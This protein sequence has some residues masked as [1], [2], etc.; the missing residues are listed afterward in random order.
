MVVAWALPFLHLELECP[1]E[2]IVPVLPVPRQGGRPGPESRMAV[3]Q[4]LLCCVRRV[5]ILT[6]VGT[7]GPHLDFTW[8]PVLGQCAVMD[9]GLA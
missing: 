8:G 2:N 3:T 6:N 9:P 7:R 1:G 5:E 4:V